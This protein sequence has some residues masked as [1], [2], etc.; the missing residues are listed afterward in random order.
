MTPITIQYSA[1]LAAFVDERTFMED[2]PDRSAYL[3]HLVDRLLVMHKKSTTS[4]RHGDMTP[5]P[6]PDEAYLSRMREQLL[7]EDA[8]RAAYVRMKQQQDR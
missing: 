6:P 5:E 2:F 8:K 7:S 4:A 3:L 1:N